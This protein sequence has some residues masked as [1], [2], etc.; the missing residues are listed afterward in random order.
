MQWQHCLY[1]LAHLQVTSPEHAKKSILTSLQGVKVS[2]TIEAL[3]LELTACQA[4]DCLLFGICR[5]E[6][7]AAWT[8]SSLKLSMQQLLSLRRMVG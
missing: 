3:R 6:A 7:K 8:S 2:L 5:A 1:L 4:H